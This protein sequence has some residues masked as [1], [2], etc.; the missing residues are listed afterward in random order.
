MIGTVNINTAPREVLIALLQGDE[1]TAD[2]VIKYR[3][4]SPFA[5]RSIGELLNIK[6]LKIKDFKKIADTLTVRSSVFNISC[7]AAMTITGARHYLE[8]VLDRAP[9]PV[10]ILYLYHGE[11]I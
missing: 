2:A 6:T 7:D 9:D 4:E 3:L 10:E 5:I 1:K 11:K 8:A